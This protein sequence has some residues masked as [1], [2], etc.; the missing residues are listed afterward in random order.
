M[1]KAMLTM[2]LAASAVAATLPA[3]AA[4][5][6]MMMPIE[7]AMNVND[8]KGRLGDTVKFYFGDQKTPKVAS[9]I[10]S[11]ST[12]QKTNSVG[13]SPEEACNWAFLSAMLAL[14]KKAESV[15]ANAV[16]NIV[17]N[18]KH[19]EM[20]SQTEFECHDGNIVSGVALKAEF[21]KLAD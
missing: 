21:V 7:G 18:Y 15:G 12:S 19:K 2:V 4:D 8:A 11:D 10:T 1:K 14:K 17:S 20:S 13:K 16:V 3:V 9:K 5:R 6:Q